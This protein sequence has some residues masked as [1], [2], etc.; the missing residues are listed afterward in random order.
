MKIVP[1]VPLPGYYYLKKGEIAKR[2][3]E[4]DLGGGKFA[5]IGTKDT[6][7]RIGRPIPDEILCYHPRRKIK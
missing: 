3:D 7:V 1:F 6:Y 4:Y 2:G 5:E